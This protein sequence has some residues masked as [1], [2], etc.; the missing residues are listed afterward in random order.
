MFSRLL[1]SALFAGLCVGIVAAALQ[2]TFVQPLLLE[3]ELFEGGAGHHAA[4]HGS[5][6]HGAADHGPA[7]AGIDWARDGLS[8]LFSL[9]VYTGYA[10]ILVA[11]MAFA[12]TRGAA[13]SVRNGVV[14]GIAGFIAVQMAP[15]FSLPPGPPGLALADLDLRQI[16]WF[17]TVVATAAALWL[18]VFGNGLLAKVAALVLLLAPHLIGA[19]AAGGFSDSVP[20]ELAAN[21]ATRSLG[22][23]LAAWSL[24]GALTAFFWHRESVRQGATAAI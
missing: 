14:W 12:E 15:A 5:A 23:G 18:L 8:V 10:L 17:L 7:A 11:L 1:T 3:A 4:D 13:L 20:P 21:F 24:L 19:P 9:L 2:L 6:G 16:W 22:V